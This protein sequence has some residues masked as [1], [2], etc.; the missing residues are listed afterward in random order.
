MGDRYL[1]IYLND[2]LAGATAGVELA[3]RAVGSNRDRPELSEPLEGVC[4]EIE[5]DRETLERVMDRL[6]VRRSAVKPAAGWLAEKLGRLKLNGRLHGYSPLSRVVE[7]EGL[8]IGI[9]GKIELWRALEQALGAE[10][11]GFDFRRLCERAARQRAAV[12]EL[13]SA[14]TSSTFSGARPAGL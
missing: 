1:S 2:H 11:S 13:H 12:E 10:W 5:A 7:L 4:A 3:R 8:C 6:E 14:A 9:S